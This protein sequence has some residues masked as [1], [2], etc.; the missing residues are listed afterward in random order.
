MPNVQSYYFALTLLLTLP[1]RS[2]S[3]T[4]TPVR[5]AVSPALAPPCIVAQCD[6]L[7]NLAHLLSLHTEEL[8][9]CTQSPTPSG[10]V[11]LMRCSALSP[12]TCCTRY[13]GAVPP[14]LASPRIATQCAEISNPTHLL[15]RLV[16][17]L[18]PCTQAPA[19]PA[20]S[21]LMRC[22]APLP[23]LSCTRYQCAVSPALAPLCVV[24][25]GA[26]ISNLTHLLSLRVEVLPP[27]T[28]FPTPPVR[29]YLM[30]C[31]SLSLTLR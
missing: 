5:C 27:S 25:Q 17:V 11:L 28:Q 6:E 8:L 2:V 16:E 14:A 23:T 1:M 21:Y 9:P 22:P 18:C 24:T 12:A 19:P 31:S 26:E 3:S 10:C 13:R 15:S 20:R 4:R 29:S 30:R 7:P